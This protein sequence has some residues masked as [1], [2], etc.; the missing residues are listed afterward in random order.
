MSNWSTYP[1]EDGNRELLKCGHG[2][3]KINVEIANTLEFSNAMNI[4]ESKFTEN[5]NVKEETIT[6]L[7]VLKNNLIT[8]QVISALHNETLIDVDVLEREPYAIYAKA[9]INVWNN[10]QSFGTIEFFVKFRNLSFAIIRQFISRSVNNI[11]VTLSNNRRTQLD[12]II[13]VQ[14][15]FQIQAVQVHDIEGKVLKIQDFVCLLLPLTLQ[16]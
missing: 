8:R 4:M 1:F 10:N 2:P 12:Y 13:A 5:N 15:S 3:N 7:N 16:S 11:E 14:D 9:K 6:L